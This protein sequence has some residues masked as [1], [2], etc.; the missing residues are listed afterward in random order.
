MVLIYKHDVIVLNIFH[1]VIVLVKDCQNYEE[2][3]LYSLH[4]W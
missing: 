2:V 1:K 4:T 3:N